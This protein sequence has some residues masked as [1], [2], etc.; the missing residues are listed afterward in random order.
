MHLVQFSTIYFSLMN[1]LFFKLAS[2]PCLPPCLSIP[3]IW[4]CWLIHIHPLSAP[5]NSLRQAHLWIQEAQTERIQ[6]THS[7]SHSLS[8]LQS[9][10]SRCTCYGIPCPVPTHRQTKCVSERN[11]LW[12]WTCL[13]KKK[14]RRSN[15][16][17]LVPLLSPPSLSKQ[18]EA[19]ASS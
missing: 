10:S 8:V 18:T 13:P 3:A 7:R 12:Q 2:V 1:N 4:R 17:Y 16:R 15:E 9:E 19:P 11:V 5:H 14:K 6:G